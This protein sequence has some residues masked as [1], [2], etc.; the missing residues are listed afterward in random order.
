MSLIHKSCFRAWHVAA[1]VTKRYAC[2][3]CATSLVPN[4]ALHAVHVPLPNTPAIQLLRAIM[5][6]FL[7]YFLLLG[8]CAVRW[9]YLVFVNY[10]EDAA[11]DAR[12]TA[13]FMLVVFTLGTYTLVPGFKRLMCDRPFSATLEEAVLNA[14]VPLEP[15]ALEHKKVWA[16]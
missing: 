11:E 9:C 1:P 8:A 12:L 16:Q 7:Y 13:V 6:L 15:L 2:D 14:C 5:G 4:A 3:V 10:H